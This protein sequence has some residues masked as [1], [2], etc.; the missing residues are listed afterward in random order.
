MICT[1][2]YHPVCVHDI[3]FHNLC[4]VSENSKARIPDVTKGLCT[5]VEKKKSQKPVTK[6]LWLYWN[7]G[8]TGLR[9]NDQNCKCVKN[10]MLW[11]PDWDIRLL[12]DQSMLQYYP[13]ITN[14][15]HLTVQHRS[16]LLRIKLLDLYG[17]V[18]AD[19]S[20]LP[21]KP[22]TPYLNQYLHDLDYF[23]FTFRNMLNKSLISSWFIVARQP[24]DPVIHRIANEVEK[25]FSR[26]SVTFPYFTFHTRVIDV[27]NKESWFRKAIDKLTVQQTLPHAPQRRH[28][29]PSLEIKNVEKHPLM[30]KRPNFNR[31]SWN[32]YNTYVRNVMSRFQISRASDRFE[33]KAQKNGKH[34]TVFDCQMGLLHETGAR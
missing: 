24:N 32:M 18:W 26:K 21:M 5:V 31:S 1:H 11:N 3:S 20:T 2:E 12:N 10:W 30:Y 7:T 22:L 4:M 14:F 13:N 8:I 17:G 25:T 34:T 19:A 33:D 15:G 16:D 9:K 6:I 27:Y 29:Y 28:P 23:F